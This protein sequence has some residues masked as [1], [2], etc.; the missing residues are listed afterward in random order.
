MP[1]CPSCGKGVVATAKTC[2]ACGKS[3]TAA[4]ASAE[5]SYD[6]M[7]EEPK[8]EPEGDPVPR[9]T[10][11][12]GAIADAAKPGEIIRPKISLR[13]QDDR[14]KEPL[15]TKGTA[16]AAVIF[17]IIVLFF[18]IRSCKTE[19]KLEGG[20]RRPQMDLQLGPSRWK[21]E[22]IVVKGG[23]TYEFEVTSVEGDFQMGLFKREP[24]TL[25]IAA[26]KSAPEGLTLIPKGETRKMDGE[27]KPGK[28]TWVVLN[29]GAKPA[30]GKIKFVAALPK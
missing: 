17:G 2:G 14:D 21:A 6:L 11:F 23:A 24:A 4:P 26:M 30:K 15:F 5:H 9:V 16:T 20:F 13:P 3:I 7:P 22:N 1:A 19:Y 10:A 27:L 28:Y 18:A 8:K 12:D 25:T 29:E